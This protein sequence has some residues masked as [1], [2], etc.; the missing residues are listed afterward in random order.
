VTVGPEF[1]IVVRAADPVDATPPMELAQQAVPPVFVDTTGRRRRHISRIAYGLGGA[2]LA[3]TV[4]LGVSLAGGP[5]SPYALRPFPEPVQWVPAASQP[6]RRDK[7]ALSVAVPPGKPHARPRP[8]AAVG[9]LP[10][11][12]S[13]RESTSDSR[14]RH[15]H[16][17]PGRVRSG[18]GK[19][20]AADGPAASANRS[21]PSPA[22]ARATRARPRAGTGD[23]PGA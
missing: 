8:A 17:P 10:A 19:F 14:A 22:A 4:L 12:H 11:T 5:V 15:D 6:Q 3:Y 7:P 2:S 18:P 23:R 21:D 20:R 16:Q 9:P 1:D 13:A